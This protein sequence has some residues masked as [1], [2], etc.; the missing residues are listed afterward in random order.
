MKT[1]TNKFK[2]N[3]SKLGRILDSKI[4]YTLNGE[5]IE[6]SKEHLNSIT[7]SFESSLLKATMK[8]LTIDSN[9]EIP[10]N[11]ILNYKFGVKVDDNFEYLDYGNYIV[12]KIEKQEDTNSYLMTCY[13]KMLYAMKDYETPN[14]IY[15]I[16]IR[17]YINAICS[18][19]GLIFKNANDT[20]VNYNKEIPNDLYSNLGYTYRNILDELAEVTASTIC[21]DENDELEIRYIND[22]ESKNKFNL[23]KIYKGAWRN[24]YVKTTK[25]DTGLKLT[26][27]QSGTQR[28]K[29]VYILDN[30]FLGKT[31]T[32]SS[33]I[34]D[35]NSQK[36]KMAFYWANMDNLVYDGL[37]GTVEGTGTDKELSLTVTLP[38]ELPQGQTNLAIFLYSGVTQ[39]NIDDYV[40]YKD[41]MIE[42]SSTKTD[43]EPAGDTIDEDFLKNVNVTFGQKFGPVNSI[44]LSRAGGSDSVY[45]QDEDSISENG[46]CEI[47][48]E[49][50]QIMNLNNRADFLPDILNQ[51]NGLEYYINDFSSTGI[52]YY[53][54]CDKYYVKVYDK[55]YKCIMFND[56]INITQ[57][58][59][60]NIHT[61]IPE[62]TE[63]EYK[64]ASKDDRQRNQ[65]YIIAKKN[66]AE[67]Q[68]LAS[69][70]IDISNTISG[71]GQIQ[72]ENAYEGILHRLEI[73]GN[74]SILY[75]SDNLYPSDDLYPIIC[76]LLV[77]ETIY[78]LDFEY[79]N[80][81]SDDVCDKYVYEDGK[82]WVERNVGVDEFGNKYALSQTIIEQGEDIE[83]RV[84]RDSI[85]KMIAF[86][87]EKLN[88]IYLLENEYTSAFANQVE[89]TSELNL[90]GDTL[91]AK[92]SQ[93]AD[94]D[95]NVTSASLI[96][97]VNND[98]SGATLNADKIS[99]EGKE[100]N[101]T[102]DDIVI[103]S[104]NF[105]V[106]ENGHIEAT[107]GD[108][109]GFELGSTKFLS[110]LNGLYNYN[111]FDL[112]MVAMKIMDRIYTDTHM[113]N[114]LDSNDSG[115]ISAVDYIRIKNIMSGVSENTKILT[116]TF[117]INSQDTKNCV[118]VKDEY[119][120]IVVGLGLGGLNTTYISCNNF[121]CGYPTDNYQD[122]VGVTI[123]GINGNITC[124]S[125]NQTS[126]KEQKK[127]FEKL[128]NALEIIKN[129][130][131]YKYNMKNEDDTDKKHIGF[132]IGDDFNYS[133]EITS[134]ENKEVDIYSFVSVCCQ[135][136]Q[137]QQ[138]EIELLKQEME[139]LK[140]EKNNF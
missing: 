100:I 117:E 111:N 124:V 119:G 64:Y 78:D 31:I 35:N 91:E 41:L 25:L 88:C 14:I 62:E 57:G 85:I 18:K 23:D 80:Y 3:I 33:K 24:D 72:L 81:I 63:T 116:G 34:T 122:F 109:G 127:N 86:N 70:I 118:V 73:T 101:L 98:T 121:V 120:S 92:V 95:G 67:I 61:E 137:E 108:I 139:K 76:N 89:V 51:L 46:L 7:P 28:W 16:T 105:N 115:T 66:E 103:H 54:V 123:N 22:T 15:P 135:A 45:L 131:I 83:I 42:I 56:E 82:Q 32:L 4:T 53:D 75:P 44:V 68:A 60:E 55:F 30:S 59:E 12:Y 1:H 27:L 130:D 126:L 48:I 134:K 125:L 52:C 133:K 102:S 90:L 69:K 37:V 128:E 65:A 11:T 50:N 21:I 43:F 106:D 6:L 114:V 20:F 40:L 112:S 49:D 110:N 8:V 9:I 26:C 132:V 93:V 17:N 136:I 84:K 140:N 87:N 74:I 5:T 97:A 2:K 47:K 79:L 107:S 29:P 104:E 96:L 19:M 94:E 58:L 38:N 39:T 113:S 138:K 77:D 36:G 129:I 13:D 71:V 10:E 99:L